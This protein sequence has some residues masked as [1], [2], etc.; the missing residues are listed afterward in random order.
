MSTFVSRFLVHQKGRQPAPLGRNRLFQA[1]SLH[2]GLALSPLSASA[3]YPSAERGQSTHLLRQRGCRQI[4]A[5]AAK[6]QGPLG[7]RGILPPH[8]LVNR[9]EVPLRVFGRTAASIVLPLQAL[10][11]GLRCPSESLHCIF[12]SVSRAE[13]GGASLRFRAKGFRV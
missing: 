13:W 7:M 5:P 6:L 8:I 9:D 11:R 12:S 10:D 2:H 1:R 3:R 4:A